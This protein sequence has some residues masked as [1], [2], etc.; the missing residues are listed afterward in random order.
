MVVP[1][2]GGSQLLCIIKITLLTYKK[3][4]SVI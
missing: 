1:I 4:S 3:V 2:S